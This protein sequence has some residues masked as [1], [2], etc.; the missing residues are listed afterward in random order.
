MF[1]ISL[2]PVIAACHCDDYMSLIFNEISTHFET[3]VMCFLHAYLC[4]LYRTTSSKSPD[5]AS[6]VKLLEVDAETR[7]IMESSGWPMVSID[8]STP[9]E[10]G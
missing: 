1:R 5:S 10:Q 2:G 6:G 8:T 9:I 7:R 4:A 3:L